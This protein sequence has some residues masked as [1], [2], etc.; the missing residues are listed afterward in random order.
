MYLIYFDE[1]GNTGNN[2]NDT[3]QPVFLLCALAV[4][5]EKWLE[6]EADLHTEIE[7]AF[8]ALRPDDFEIHAMDLMSGR[9]WFKSIPL[10]RRV[11]FRDAWFLVAAKHELTII[12][13]AAPKK[14]FERWQ[15]RTFG[16]GIA[17]NPHVVVFPMVARVVDDWLKSLPDSPLG[18][19]ISDENKE[20]VRDVEK[21]IKALRGIGGPLKLAQIIEKG[22]FID[23]S[24]SVILQLCDLCAYTLRKKVEAKTGFRDNPLHHG[25]IA[26]LDPLVH[27]G[28]ENVQDV[29]QWVANEK[30]KGTHFVEEFD[31]SDI[32]LEHLQEDVS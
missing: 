3:Q 8:P 25:G 14:S 18:I 32:D 30:K 13:L 9:G 11:A 5:K 23:S 2:L 7:K 20:I 17:I 24:K 10:D 29:L 26:L 22:F 27:R 4:P 6:V 19:F 1:S 16:S 21:S 28:N 31:L 12:Y 15:H